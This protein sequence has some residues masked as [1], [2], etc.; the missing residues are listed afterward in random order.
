VNTGYRPKDDDVICDFRIEPLGISIKEAAGGVAAENSIGAWTELSTMKSYVADLHAT[1]FRLQRNQARIAYPIDLFEPGNPSN[2]L[3]S[4]AGNVFGLKA[5]K[6]LRLEDVHLPKRLVRSFDGPKYG[7]KGIREILKIPE[8]PLLGTI[9]K[10]KL[11][12]KTQDHAKVTY[13]A[14]RGGCDIV[15]D[16]ENLSNQTFNRFEDR[17]VKTLDIRD[18]A[19]E[20]TG[21]RKV[22]MINVTAETEEMVRRAEFVEDQGGEY[23]MVDI[24]RASFLLNSFA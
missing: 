1:V 10:P 6:N 11:G 14:W 21:E 16:D 7:I 12:L 13:D 9:I 4:V 2:I 22:Y 24:A 18:R 8:R 23:I 20:E 19:E 3:S 5:V 17:V 15:K